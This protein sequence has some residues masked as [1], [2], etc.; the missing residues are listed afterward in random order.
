VRVEVLTALAIKTAVTYC[1]THCVK[2]TNFSGNVSAGSSET[3]VFSY[4][5]T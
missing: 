5:P 2:Y 3:L 1:A 4:E